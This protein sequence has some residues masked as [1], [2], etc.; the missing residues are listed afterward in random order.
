MTAVNGVLLLLAAAGHAELWVALI[1][2]LH[3][4]PIPPERLRRIR[5]LHDLMIPGGAFA[6]LVGLGLTGARLLV[7]GSWNEVSGLW[8]PILLASWLG[9]VGA[10]WE[11]RGSISLGVAVR[12]SAPASRSTRF[13]GRTEPGQWIRARTI[14]WQHFL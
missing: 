3:A 11:S 14:D 10:F 12:W 9:A 7:G 2:R 8:Y 13:G 6:I 1:N 5:H 4:L